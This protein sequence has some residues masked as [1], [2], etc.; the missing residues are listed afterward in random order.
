[1]EKSVLTKR[2]VKTFT[3]F[4][5]KNGEKQKIVC[6]IRY[7]D[8]CGNG[9]NTFAITGDGYRQAKN[10]RWVFTFGGC[11]H[12]EIKKHFPEFA[13]LIKW[14]LCNSDGPMCYIEN[15]L[16]LAGDR[17]CWGRAKGEP[18]GFAKSVRFSGFP[19]S[20]D[21]GEKFIE[22]VEKSRGTL[23]DLEIVKVEHKNA[24]GGYQ[25][26]PKYTFNCFPCEWYQCPFDSIDKARE[27]LTAFK[28]KDFEVIETPT[29]YSE[30]KNREF[31]AARHSAIWE[32]ASEEILSLPPEEL[33]EKLLERLPA[34][35]A[36][37]KKDIESLGFVY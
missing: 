25:Y 30:G 37:F 18:T 36:E 26:S 32:D 16:Y 5:T 33:K 12:D 31:E 9:H 15:T 23:Q 17:D 22:S 7:D 14:H 34:L 24:S 29:G 21:L 8:E 13:H 4:Y 20:F 1:M 28:T 2:Q 11:C 35:I 27:L 6:E 10:G 3:K 19:V